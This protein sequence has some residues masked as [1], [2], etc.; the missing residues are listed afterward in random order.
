MNPGCVK[1]GCTKSMRNIQTGRSPRKDLLE[2]VDDCLTA[3]SVRADIIHASLT[4]ILYTDNIR[5]GCLMCCLLEYLLHRC[6]WQN[7]FREISR[8]YSL[9]GGN[10]EIIGEERLYCA[11]DSFWPQVNSYSVAGSHVKVL[12]GG[13][14]QKHLIRMQFCKMHRL[15]LSVSHWSINSIKVRRYGIHIHVMNREVGAQ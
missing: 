9:T 12:C 10:A 8:L 2:K 15:A 6:Q 11:G 1:L 5:R 4:I 3:T 7:N 13:S 14:T